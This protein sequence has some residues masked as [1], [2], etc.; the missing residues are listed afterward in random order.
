MADNGRFANPLLPCIIEQPNC[1]SL[2]YNI[3]P[4][5]SNLIATVI[6]GILSTVISRA[7]PDRSFLQSG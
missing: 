5:P 1:L 3:T 7:Q 2:N 6:H 4:L